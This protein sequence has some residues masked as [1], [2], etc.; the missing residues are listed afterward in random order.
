MCSF[1]YF[2]LSPLTWLIRKAICFHSL[3]FAPEQSWSSSQ[4]SQLSSAPKMYY[5]ALIKREIRL[6]FTAVSTH[7]GVFS[8]NMLCMRTHHPNS[9]QHCFPL[10]AW[11][12]RADA[13]LILVAASKRD[14]KH[15]KMHHSA[16]CCTGGGRDWWVTVTG[17]KHFWPPVGSEEWERTGL[18][19]LLR[20]PPALLLSFLIYCFPL[21]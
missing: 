16:W 7:D 1:T 10:P 15:Y 4:F 8:T 20:L 6:K 9:T 17:V 11:N 3:Y 21:Q 2:T 5:L 13:G 14:P 19:L 18:S 12:S